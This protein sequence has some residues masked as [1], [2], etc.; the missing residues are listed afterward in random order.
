[1]TDL[2][3]QIDQQHR[4]VEEV[5]N[6]A[7]QIEARICRIQGAARYLPHRRYGSAVDGNEI[8]KNLTLASLIARRDAPLAAYLGVASGEHRRREEEAEAR[9]M[10]AES[11]RLQTERLRQQ[12]QQAQ[13]QRYQQ[14]LA[15]V[16]QWGRPRWAR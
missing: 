14:Q 16:D 12:N 6:Q 4:Q 13:H 8:R 9:A 15:G 10:A 2:D 11:M 5:E 7:R 1:M 3:S